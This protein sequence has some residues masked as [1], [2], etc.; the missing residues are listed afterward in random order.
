MILYEEP[1]KQVFISHSSKDGRIIRLIEQYFKETFKGSILPFFANK[2]ITGENPAEKITREMRNSKVLF[3]LM[4][5]NVVDDRKTRDWV[6]FE[7]G[8]AKGIGKK[9][10]AWK[11][12]DIEV[13]EPVTMIT[14][15]V[16]FDPKDEEDIKKVVGAM[17]N[18][19]YDLST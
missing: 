11:T 2:W 15:Y 4:T 18:I 9:I 19:A 6:L 14:D 1:T 13:P 3:V 17:M 7:I 16:P 10:Y 8:I 12:V 5:K